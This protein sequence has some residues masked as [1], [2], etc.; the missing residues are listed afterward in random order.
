M[1]LFLRKRGREQE[2]Y[3]CAIASLS[4]REPPVVS[5]PAA[6]SVTCRAPIP[7]PIQMQLCSGLYRKRLKAVKNPDTMSK[8]FTVIS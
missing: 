3:L 5:I 1:A 2:L 7:G 6:T 8:F 4:C